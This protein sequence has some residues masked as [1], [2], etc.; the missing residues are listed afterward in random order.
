MVRADTEFEHVCLD[1]IENY[2]NAYLWQN[3]ET[4]YFLRRGGDWNL[5]VYE[6]TIKSE[7]DIRDEMR[8]DFDAKD[9]RIEQ[10]RC[11]NTEQ[12][13]D[14]WYNDVNIYDYC[15]EWDYY[16]TAEDITEQLNDLGF[17]WSATDDYYRYQYLCEDRR[18]A[19]DK[20]MAERL[21]RAIDW[22]GTTNERLMDEIKS[23][24]HMNELEFLE[25]E[26]IR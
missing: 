23:L 6:V 13:Y 20:S 25:C 22:D 21:M 5:S 3:W 16:W 8:D 11:W 2:C 19:L 4:Y 26:N 18:W 1:N 15:A 14:D 17:W 12:G 7:D 9:E 24:Y 10:V